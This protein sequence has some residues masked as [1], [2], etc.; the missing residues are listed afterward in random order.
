MEKRIIPRKNTLQ[1]IHAKFKE[2]KGEDILI[3]NTH[4]YFHPTADHIR[5]IHTYLSLKHM[6]MVSTNI[7]VNRMFALVLIYFSIRFFLFLKENIP[8]IIFCGDLN[9]DPLS[10]AMKLLENGSI[11]NN[12]ESFFS[13]GEE[14][15]IPNCNFKSSI[16]F[17][18][19]SGYP[20]YTHYLLSFQS[21]L[22]YVLVESDKFETIRTVPMP[23]HEQVTLLTALPNAVF[24]SD[25]LPLICDVKPI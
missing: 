3:A 18:S 19:A 6:E 13:S 23:T 11:S 20:E 4:S 9:S 22:D 17:K 21:C 7:K 10:G 14:Q 5:L 1:L 25:H 15:Y 12:H 2:G 24:P 16:K 8:R